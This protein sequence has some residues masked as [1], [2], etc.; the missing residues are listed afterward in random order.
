MENQSTPVVNNS[1]ADKKHW[2]YM[3]QCADG[4][5][6][7]GWTT[8]IERRLKAHNGQIPGGAKY[9]AGRRPVSLAWCQSFATKQEAQSREYAVKQLS[10]KEKEKLVA[11]YASS[12]K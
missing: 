8:D 10:K 3:V 5:L 2:T 1:G 9:T 4:S 12:T 11:T 7:T 6:Y